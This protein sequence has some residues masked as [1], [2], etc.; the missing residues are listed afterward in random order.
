MYRYCLESVSLFGG[1]TDRQSRSPLG[2]RPDCGLPQL[3]C[4]GAVI[5]VC[6]CLAGADPDCVAGADTNP[7]TDSTAP[8]QTFGAAREV[9]GNLSP[10]ACPSGKPRCPS[11]RAH[12][13]SSPFHVDLCSRLGASDPGVPGVAFYFV[14]PVTL[15]VYLRVQGDGLRRFWESIPPGSSKSRGEDAWRTFFEVTLHAISGGLWHEVFRSSTS[16]L[17]PS[18]CDDGCAS[19][20]S[21][22]TA[23]FPTARTGRRP[24]RPR[25]R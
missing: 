4:A 6:D 16:R 7:G 22:E 19:N 15:D 13:T 14:I 17:R 24:R 1:D 21:A 3:G 8:M 20:S 18:T 11:T 9:F 2:S 23:W 25:R 5:Y 10:E 12:E